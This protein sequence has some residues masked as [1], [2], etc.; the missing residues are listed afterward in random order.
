MPINEKT[1]WLETVDIPAP[2][3]HEFPQRVDV[4]VIGAGFTGLS[5]ARSLARGGASVAAFEAQTIGWGAS[6]RNGGMVLTGLKLPAGRLISRYGTEATARMYAASLESIDFVEKLVRE[7]NIACDFARC[8]HLEVACKPKHF[9]DFRRT[10]EE[11]ERHFNHKQRIISKDQLQS[12]IGSAIY[13]GGLVD[14]TSAGLNPSRFVAG[15]AQAAE[16]AGA[17]IF[18]HSHVDQIQREAAPGRKTPPSPRTP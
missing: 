5:A 6:S 2:A 4:A 8:G 14:A 10:A 7:E 9:D 3:P 1:F 18:H 13:H 15:L 16:R 17:T 12:E 11:T